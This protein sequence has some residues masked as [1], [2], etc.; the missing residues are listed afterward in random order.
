MTSR[1][2]QALYLGQS[3]KL[4]SIE[5]VPICAPTKTMSILTVEDQCE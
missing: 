4:S 2:G 5:T 3:R 1:P